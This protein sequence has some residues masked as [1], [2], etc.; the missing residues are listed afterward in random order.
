MKMCIY[1]DAKDKLDDLLGEL[2]GKVNTC[3]LFLGEKT[4]EVLHK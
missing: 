1:D 3:W 2:E 4:K